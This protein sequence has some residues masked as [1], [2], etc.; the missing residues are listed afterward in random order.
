MKAEGPGEINGYQSL[1]QGQWQSCPAM[2]TEG[3]EEEPQPLW[4][5]LPELS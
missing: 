4:E 5:E 2:A 1:T 3:P